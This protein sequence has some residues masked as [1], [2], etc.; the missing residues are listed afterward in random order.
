[1]NPADHPPWIITAAIA[2]AS[3]F[4]GALIAIFSEPVRKWIFRPRLV[5]EFHGD[6]DDFIVRTPVRPPGEPEHQAFGIRGY[7]HNTGRTTAYGCCAWLINIE[8]K[9]TT[10][11]TFYQTPYHEVLPLQWSNCPNRDDKY[12]AEIARGM[13]QYFDILM[14]NAR[15]D[16]I[17]T[18]AESMPFRFESLLRQHGDFRFTIKV[19]GD[20]FGPVALKIGLS[21]SGQWDNFKT[22]LE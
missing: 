15:R 13:G 4:L 10:S 16:D 18:F 12:N 2:L 5:A 1:M 22:W 6:R 19:A 8:K 21:W 17:L 20:D 14:F 11:G 7:V 9:N 3:S